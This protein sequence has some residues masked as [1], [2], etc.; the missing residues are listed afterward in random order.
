MFS[1]QKLNDRANKSRATL[2]QRDKPRT[3]PP[4]PTHRELRDAERARRAAERAARGPD[5]RE[6]PEGATSPVE[7]PDSPG[8]PMAPPSAGGA[9]EAKP[10]PKD[11][12]DKR[13]QRNAQGLRRAMEREARM[14]SDSRARAL[15][16][17]AREVSGDVDGVPVPLAM[18][19]GAHGL[20]YDS[21]RAQLERGE[22]PDLAVARERGRMLATRKACGDGPDA[23]QWAWLAERLAPRELHLPTRVTGVA[24]EDGGAPIATATLAV[25][26]VEARAL[27][28]DDYAGPIH[29]LPGAVIPAEGPRK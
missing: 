11:S 28:R 26:L 3:L 20:H 10:A 16:A 2:A 8:R 5:P 19:C 29:A 17:I 12:R 21:V 22:A 1:G 7:P 25:T 14:G 13:A 6:A 18:A 15:E 27:A 4:M 24:A 9:P 23:R